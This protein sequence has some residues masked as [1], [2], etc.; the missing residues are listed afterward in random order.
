MSIDLDPLTGLP[1]RRAF[2]ERF[3]AELEA[4]GPVAAML[5]DIKDTRGLNDVYGHS[6][7]DKLIAA[8]ARRLEAATY[9]GDFVARLG[10]D[11]FIVLASSVGRDEDDL[12]ALGREVQDGISGEPVRVGGH[13]VQVSVTIKAGLLEGP[14][15]L[16]RLDSS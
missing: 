14:E 1:N 15:D 6:L 13:D 5:L 3:A 16:G 9:A 2:S 4:G 8:V 7:V 11:E 12:A 10:G